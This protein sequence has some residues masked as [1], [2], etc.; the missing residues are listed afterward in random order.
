MQFNLPPNNDEYHI[1]PPR[2]R[3][4]GILPPPA[5]TVLPFSVENVQFSNMIM[6][7]D[8]APIQVTIADTENVDFIRNISFSN[9]RFTSGL[10]PIFRVRP[11]DN[12]RD[13]RFSDVTFTVEPKRAHQKLRL[14]DLG[15]RN[16]R[17]FTF[18]NVVWDWKSAD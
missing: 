17:N 7:S 10:P 8:N 14:E 1:D 3:K 4:N 13:W 12:V 16:C 2:D 15:F 11:Q 18:D 5:G 9:C 6:C